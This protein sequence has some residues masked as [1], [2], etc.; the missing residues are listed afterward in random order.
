ME[1]INFPTLVQGESFQAFL[2]NN[3]KYIPQ[4]YL[5][6]QVTPEKD[7]Q[8]YPAEDFAAIYQGQRYFPIFNASETIA[9]IMA[10]LYLLENKNIIEP[11]A[12]SKI[13]YWLKAASAKYD[14]PENDILDSIEDP[15]KVPTD[16]TIKPSELNNDISGKGLPS[17]GVNKMAALLNEDQYALKIDGQNY[18]N[19]STPPD[20][21]K[22][23]EI[24]ERSYKRLSPKDR[25]EC[26]GHIKEAA[27]NKNVTVNNYPILMRYAERQVNEFTKM[28][29]DDRIKACHNAETRQTLKLIKQAAIETLSKDKIREL[30]ETL[31][32]IDKTA[33]WR[34]HIDT[35]I[36]DAYKTF[37]LVKTANSDL[38]GEAVITSY[39]LINLADYYPDLTKQAI[40]NY[41]SDP[42][43][44]LSVIHNDPRGAWSKY[45]DLREPLKK[46]F[47]DNKDALRT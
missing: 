4:E 38:P 16:N 29:L 47:Y 6:V 3:S 30:A 31:D 39:D 45:P 20:I 46:L 18:I 27:V 5:G 2:K 33:D 1:L 34:Y 19:I 25:A 43:K 21:V 10:F 17:I 14:L 37:G 22:A 41:F 8:D 24:F 42:D 23:A 40:A 44:M 28:A 12:I 26:A 15:P 13:A 35:F 11:G 32:E 9:S 36:P 7:Y